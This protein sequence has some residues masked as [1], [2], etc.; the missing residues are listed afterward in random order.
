MARSN[1]GGISH[2]AQPRGVLPGVTSS[3]VIAQTWDPVIDHSTLLPDAV[4]DFMGVSGTPVNVPTSI[5]TVLCA[6]PS[7]GLTLSGSPGVPF[8][9]PTPADCSLAGPS[10]RSQGGALNGA[11][12]IALAN[13]IDVTIG[14]F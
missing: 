8:A 12:A 4:A 14:T 11:G 10:L 13:A 2:A 5:S 6:A 7:P 3:P 1:N 9:L